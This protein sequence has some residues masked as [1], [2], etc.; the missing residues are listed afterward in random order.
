MRTLLASLVL[1]APASAQVIEDFEHGN[2]GLYVVAAGTADTFNVV[3]GAAHD[4]AFGGEFIQGVGPSWR[5]RSDLP[6]APGNVYSVYV[7]LRGGV[8][9][10]GR[11]YMGVG[12]D[13]AGAW[14]AVFAPNT[15]QIILQNNSNFGFITA[16]TAAATIVPD[17]WYQMRLDWAANGDMTLDLLDE[18]GTN[19][20]ATTGPIVT[21]YTNP[22]GIVLRGFTTNAAAFHD[23]DTISGPVGSIGT[24]Y[25]GP[26]VPNSTG[27]SGAMSATGSNVVAN[28]DLTL[29]ASDLPNNAFGFFLT[30]LSQGNVP[31][32][33]GSLGVL[34][35]GG[36]IGRYV[37]PGQIQNT[38][39]TGS[40]SLLLDLT[41]TPTPTG[42]ISVAAGETRNF[43]AWHRDNVGGNAVSNFTDGLSVTFN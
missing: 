21:G 32:P 10:N 29:V 22:G 17:V 12:A 26:A 15:S 18:A 1:L 20:L 8:A 38:G 24:N 11:S 23:F 27:A 41:Q 42:F 19:V 28:N 39:L 43:Q 40:F 5:L 37:G 34:C 7:R 4:G 14:S 31:Q 30:S 2:E 16:A 36:S 25:C 33:G 6:T 3:A 13:A 9:G 35:L